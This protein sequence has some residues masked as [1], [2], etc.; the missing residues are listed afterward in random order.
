MLATV[1]TV[2][3]VPC[4]FMLIWKIR[5]TNRIFVY[6]IIV[7][8]GEPPPKSEESKMRDEKSSL[9]LYILQRF[10]WMFFPVFPRCHP[11]L[12]CKQLVK[13]GSV[14]K[15][16]IACDLWDGTVC[17]CEQVCGFFHADLHAVFMQ[18]HSG[19]F[20]SDP[21][22]EDLKSVVLGSDLQYQCIECG[23]RYLP[24][25]AS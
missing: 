12:S 5:L 6:T 17:F 19:V 14:R 21:V 18:R 10:A 9:S 24:W 22:H 25:G 1:W 15:L 13:I 3:G 11:I 23:G 7:E 2:T 8:S 16:Q 20:F 4:F